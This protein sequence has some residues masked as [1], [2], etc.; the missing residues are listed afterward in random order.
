MSTQPIGPKPEPNKLREMDLSEFADPPE[1]PSASESKTTVSGPKPETSTVNP[2]RIKNAM[3]TLRF[4][5]MKL[6]PLG[7][8]KPEAIA[9]FS[10]K[11]KELTG[12]DDRNAE[13]CYEYFEQESKSW[14][15]PAIISSRAIVS[16][17]SPTKTT[18]T[19]KLAKGDRLSRKEVEQQ[20]PS[21]ARQLVKAGYL[22]E[23]AKMVLKEQ[24]ASKDYPLADDQASRLFD[25]ALAHHTKVASHY[26]SK[27]LIFTPT[28]WER[29]QEEILEDES[30]VL[31]GSPA[32]VIVRPS[33]KTIIEGA[34]KSFKTTLIY[35][36][37]MGMAFGH[38]V[39]SKLPVAQP[40]KVLYL[41]GEL[42]VPELYQRRKAAMATIPPELASARDEFFLDGRSIEA[43]LIREKGQAAI[44]TLVKRHKPG[45]LI[46]DPWQQ[47]IEGYDENS[48]KDTSTATE[49]MDRLMFEIPGMAIFLVAHQGKD[50][51]KG[52]RGHSSLAGWR[53]NL[54]RVKRASITNLKATVSVSPRWTMAPFDFRVRFENGTMVEDDFSPQTAKIREFVQSRKGATTTK[55]DIEAHLGI[56]PDAAKKA[57]QRAVEE[58]G[59]DKDDKGNYY[60]GFN[61]LDDEDKAG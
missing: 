40:I 45:L 5:F 17:A 26:D 43:H 7:L 42:V 47:F 51:T 32:G 36:Q 49:F 10:P 50:R 3:Q 27:E 53:D 9:K 12:L 18:P 14:A 31:I 33:T 21:L 22:R 52:M 34:E 28:Q 2:Q 1:I 44:R 35:R 38:T 37:A 6:Q 29:V 13:R 4:Q 57:I 54:I 23:S 19:L 46:I 15:S 11:F 55:A 60:V 61:P 48:F 20:L 25:E 41:H 59:I 16:S 30:P 58:G 56:S 39:Y 24:A 8:A